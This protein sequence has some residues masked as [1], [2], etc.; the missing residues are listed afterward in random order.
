VSCRDGVSHN[1]AE[2]CRSEASLL[3]SREIKILLLLQ[4]MVLI[5]R[6]IAVQKIAEREPRFYL[7]QCFDMIAYEQKGRDMKYTSLNALSNRLELGLWMR[8]KSRES[9][10]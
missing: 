1:P 5:L 3:Y 2:Y 4:S 8:L 6:V 7:E 9:T 10:V